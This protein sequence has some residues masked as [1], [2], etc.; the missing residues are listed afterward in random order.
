FAPTLS[1]TGAPPAG[2]TVGSLADVLARRRDLVEPHLGR[3]ARY[4]TRPFVALN[5]AFLHDGAFVHVPRGAVVR[6]PIH[7]IFLATP[8]NEPA[9]S[10]PRTLIVAEGN[11]QC[12]LAQSYA[13]LGEGTYF[14]N[15]VTEVETG[16]NAFID[17]YKIQR[18]GPSAF[19]LETLQV[20][21][22][23]ASNFSSHALTLGGKWARNESGA[24]L[25]DEGCECTLNGLYL[26][27]GTQH[28][29]NR[30][31]IDHAKPHCSS[32]ELYK[33]ILDGKA[34]AVFNGKIYVRQDA[35][36]TDAKQTNQTLLLS[37]DAVI[38]TKPQL[39][40]FADD[41]KCTHGATIGQ[42]SA[43]A[44]F[45]LRSR[46]IGSEAARALLTYAFANDVVERIK[47]DPLRRQLEDFLLARQHLPAVPT[48]EA[49]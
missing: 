8:T 46:G 23:R 16:P 2:V 13:G 37:E 20:R 43:D 1:A 29:D 14:T 36:K 6:E 9:V 22:G 40:I 24:L 25:A 48:E 42:L 18:E 30:T 10:Y 4:E 21:L 3:L 28:V 33:G 41:V 11:C 44:L 27:G 12:T 35:Q 19:H 17:H 47:F 45:Y 15:A 39:E 38:N 32:H 5:T 26:A 49:P 34:H 7:L 31:V